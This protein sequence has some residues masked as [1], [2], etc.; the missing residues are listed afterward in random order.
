MLK[1]YSRNP[2]VKD[3]IVLQSRNSHSRCIAAKVTMQ[4]GPKTQENWLI[5][6]KLD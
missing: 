1:R 2:L 5:F 4:I 6:R 3:T